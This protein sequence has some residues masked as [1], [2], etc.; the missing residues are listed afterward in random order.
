MSRKYPFKRDFYKD[1]VRS[2]SE[3]GATFVLG[4]RKCGKTVCLTQVRDAYG[5]AEYVDF[6]R[7]TEREGMEVLSRVQESIENDEDRIY[8]LDEM[9]YAPNPE[10]YVCEIAYLFTEN[11]PRNTRVVFSGSQSLALDKWGHIAFCGSAGFIRT[12]FLSYAEWLR[13]KSIEKPSEK[14]YERF[15][16]E[17]PGFMGVG[18]MGEYLQGCLEE[19]AIS[20][21]NTSNYL[22]GNDCKLLNAEILLDVCYATLF[23]LHNHVSSDTFAK[24]GYLRKDIVHY[25]REIC[26]ELDLDER[27]Q[28]SF[29][30]RY[31]DYK[32]MD[33]QTLEQAFMFL[34]N[35]GLITVT[36]VV[37]DLENVPD[38]GRDFR[39]IAH[40]GDSNTDFKE[41]LFRDFNMCI[42]Y[43]AFYVAILRDILK[44]QM[45]DRLP[46]GLLGSIVECHVRG[47]LPEIWSAEYHDDND[48]EIDYVNTADQTAVEI[49]V[50]NKPM[51]KTHFGLLPDGYR[52]FLLTKDRD[53][54]VQGVRRVPYYEFLYSGAD[55]S[56][57]TKENGARGAESEETIGGGDG[58]GKT[59][60][61]IL[62]E[63]DGAGLGLEEM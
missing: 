56:A 52:K 27:I 4:P 61:D 58:N 26:K 63:E 59:V 3:N 15:L 38:I 54:Y 5:N 30:S 25:F 40:G 51:S 17:T 16:Y 20:N 32:K 36:P 2:I 53:D 57:Y 62:A 42:R 11:A 21:L 41:G 8:L 37:N 18:S 31:T 13:Y 48:N 45:P 28:N 14:S 33:W 49:T 39:L 22:F 19:T 29:V 9:T 35:C 23:T 24:G 46:N 10:K 44:E 60:D 12:D 47:M 1:V 34:K 50:S 55:F 43:P 6:K 7:K